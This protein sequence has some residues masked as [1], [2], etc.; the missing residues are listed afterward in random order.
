[1]NVG[2]C[3]ISD[4]GAAVE[5]V[6]ALAGDV[7]YDGVEV[8]GRDHVGD[9]SETTCRRIANATAE[10]G[11]DL[12]TYG[13]YLRAGTDDFAE[14][15]PRELAIAD[16]LGAD[17]I[18]VWAGRE[19]YG[20]QDPEYFDRVAADLR[21]LTERAADIGV[22][23]T[24]EKHAGTLTNTLEGARHLVEAVDHPDCGLNYQ[25]GFSLPADVIDR[26]VETLGSLTNYCHLQAVRECGS[27]DR[28]PLSEAFYDVEGVL[29]GLRRGG[30]DGYVVVEFVTDERPYREA[31]AAD[32]TYLRSLV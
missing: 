15:L 32:L 18:R 6:I 10:A 8:W 7:G 16:R 25:P 21:E 31:I 2:L 11:L 13:S 20:D 19:E 3:T 27:S 14:A 17:L 29:D 24:V 23:V 30:F 26:E 1:M 5:D 22:A 9:G 12:P 4:K 28:C